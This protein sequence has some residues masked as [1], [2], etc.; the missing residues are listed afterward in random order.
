MAARA[1]KGLLPGGKYTVLVCQ[2]PGCALSKSEQIRIALEQAVKSTGLSDVT[3]DFTGCHGLC[4]QGPLVI[5]EPEGIFYTRVTKEDVNDIVH[6]H[7]LRGR[8]VER[9]LYRDPVTNEIA[10]TYKEIAFYKKQKRLVLRNCGHI[11]PESIDAYLA[12]GGYEALKKVL[13]RMSS[14]QVID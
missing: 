6:S 4:Q 9:L 7:L 3:I 2:G 14:D 5:I 12:A 8:C 10:T 13:S 1:K 11:N